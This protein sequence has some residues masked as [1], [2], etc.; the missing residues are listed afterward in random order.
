MWED[1]VGVLSVDRRREIAGDGT[2]IYGT[3][4]Y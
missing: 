2:G 1:L 3:V 4:P